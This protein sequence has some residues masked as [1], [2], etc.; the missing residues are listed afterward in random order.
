MLVDGSDQRFDGF[1]V[2]FRLAAAEH[3]RKKT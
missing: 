3:F 2:F 1:Y